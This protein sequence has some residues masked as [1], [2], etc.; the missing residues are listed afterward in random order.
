[1]ESPVLGLEKIFLRGGG[2]KGDKPLPPVKV[3]QPLTDNNL[4]ES[5]IT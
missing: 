3:E 4:H 5:L 1:V 2:K